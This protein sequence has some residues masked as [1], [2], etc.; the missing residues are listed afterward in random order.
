MTNNTGFK[1]SLNLLLIEDSKS[2]ALLIEK[3]LELAMHNEYTLRK[4]MTLEAALNLLPHHQFDVALLDRSLP[5][6]E[7]FEGLHSIQNMAPEL[8]IVFL[9]SYQNEE[10]ALASIQQGAQDYLLKG[11]SDGLVIK[12]AIQFAILRK[13]FE[14]VLIER[15]NFDVLTGLANRWLF[16][17]RLDMAIAKLKRHQ[18]IFAV[19]Y[20][21]LD[22][23]K[24]IN[25]EYGHAAGDEALKEVA[26]RLRQP[27]REYDTPARLG[28]DE[29]AILL[30]CITALPDVELVAKRLITLI[31][32]PITVFGK[33]VKVGVS[34][35]IVTSEYKP[36]ITAE[37]LMDQADEF[38]YQAKNEPGSCYCISDGKIC[39]V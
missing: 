17:N 25:D 24:N 13:K 18:A 33:E 36:D 7:N 21:D 12:R 2:D 30:D 8:P 28:G 38:M 27:L 6:A 19:L 22:F 26:I 23:F 3:E 32:K 15:A 34:M 5:D 14:F 10:T 1:T 9:T 29:F 37:A 31:E 35:G 39:R 16:K 4:A 11:K 20:L